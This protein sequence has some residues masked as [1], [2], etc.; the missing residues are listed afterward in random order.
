VRIDGERSRAP[1]DLG[2]REGA[3]VRIT[4]VDRGSGLSPDVVE[5]MF[6]PFFTT[7]GA[8]EGTGLGLPVAQGIAR[9]HGG[10]ISVESAQDLG[11][12]FTIHLPATSD[13]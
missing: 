5:H 4:V 1:A 7:K 6:E 11:T 13:G 9:D 2:G 3:F 12:R 8:E 10:W